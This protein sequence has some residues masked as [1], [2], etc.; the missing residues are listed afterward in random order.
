MKSTLGCL[1]LLITMT[2]VSFPAAAATQNYHGSCSITF[3]VQKT[4]IKDFT[5]TAVCEPFEI[6]I[7]DNMV[8]VPVIAVRVAA[9]DTGNRN[10]DKEMY[11]MFEHEIFPLITGNTGTFAAD[12]FL[13]SEHEI[14]STPEEISFALTIRDITKEVTARVTEPQIDSSTLSATLDFDVSLSSFELSPPS[15]LGIIKV[16]DAVKIKVTMSLDRNPAAT[17]MPQ[18][19]E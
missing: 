12:E 6:S 14:A 5:G 4:I 19:Q 1:L 18:A 17:K 2:L 15:F 16:Q 7:A 8:R 11:S 3:Q 13:T 10:R 9:M